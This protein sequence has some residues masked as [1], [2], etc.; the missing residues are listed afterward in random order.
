M[1]LDYIAA[2]A[3][4]PWYK[5]DLA[6]KIGQEIHEDESQDANKRIESE[7]HNMVEDLSIRDIPEDEAEFYLD[8]YVE[9]MHAIV[10][11]MVTA[12]NVR[13]AAE[14]K[15]PVNNSLLKSAMDLVKSATNTVA[16]LRYATKWNGQDLNDVLRYY[17][18]RRIAS[19]GETN[20]K[21]ADN[22]RLEE[23]S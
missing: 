23:G 20:F 17:E 16:E 14:N 18:E 1:R 11:P 5:I 4:I 19:S 13:H 10:Q 21:S 7:R 8:F 12:S 15:E 22:P 2:N 6:R 9:L 3:R